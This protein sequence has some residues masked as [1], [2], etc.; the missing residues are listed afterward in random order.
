MSGRV[1]LLGGTFDPI[2][3]GHLA[4]AAAA[5]SELALDQVRFI[6]SSVPPHRPDTPRASGYHRLQM[7]ALAV[8]GHAGW[9]ASDV[10]LERG[11]ASYTCDTLATL[12]RAE[13]AAQFFF[14]TGADAFAE[15][16]AWRHYPGVL[17]QAHF[18]VIARTGSSFDGL[19]ARYPRLMPRMVEVNDRPA[20]S[21]TTPASPSIFLINAATPDVSSTE[22]RRRASAGEPLAGLVPDAVADYIAEHRLYA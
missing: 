7:T 6:P 15:I 13:P 11:G 21:G 17:D 3:L 14:I 2:H 20:T 18:V 19:K 9:Q 12:R 1:G 16:A 8:A 10:E 22:V 5:Q 4:A